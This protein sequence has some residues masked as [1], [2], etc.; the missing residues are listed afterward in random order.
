[1]MKAAYLHHDAG[2]VQQLLRL[3]AQGGITLR[4]LHDVLHD[5]VVVLHV[6]QG[7]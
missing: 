3:R 1:M 6:L 5:D 2:L 4:H 7:L